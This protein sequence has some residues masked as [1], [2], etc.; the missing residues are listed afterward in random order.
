MTALVI[1]DHPLVRLGMQR[2]LERMPGM[3]AVHAMESARIP[4]LDTAREASIVLYGMSED[5]TSNWYLLR[6]L[7]AVRPNARILLLSDDMRLHVPATLEAF[8]VVKHLPR[9]ASIE[10]MEAVVLQMLAS[11]GMLPLRTVAATAWHA[12]HPP[13]V[14]S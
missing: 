8:G 1:D 14:L 6:R 5:A 13:R 3:G 11:D 12:H 4:A 2:L 9:S 10:R 7:K